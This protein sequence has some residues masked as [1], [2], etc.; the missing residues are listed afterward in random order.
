MFVITGATGNTGSV[1][2]G[3]LLAQ[4]KPVTVLVRDTRKA[5]SWREKGAQVAVASSG[6]HSSVGERRSPARKARTF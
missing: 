2:A 1:V 3:T 4:G 6:G 5:E